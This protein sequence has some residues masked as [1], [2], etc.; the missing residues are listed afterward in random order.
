MVTTLRTR[1]T[2]RASLS[3]VVGRD[4]QATSNAD[5]ARGL[6]AG[7][8]WAISE[9]WHRFAPRVLT[10]AE[11]AVGSRCEAEDLAQEV[12][13]Q[14]FRN[15]ASLREPESLRSFVYSIALRVVRLQLRR[16]RLRAWLLF[17]GP[18]SL[19]D[20]RHWSLDLE[21]RELLRKFYA[22]LERLPPRDRLVFVLRRIDAMTVEEVAAAMDLSASTVKRSML[23]ATNR[24]SRWI[25]ADRTLKEL[26]RGRFTAA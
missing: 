3:L 15:V 17:Q 19:V 1:K 11:R 8:E 12:F 13:Y 26:V 16:R 2:G 5:L 24:L 18:E 20:S 14:V 23:Y 6:I 7:E 22:L 21:S 4:P 10:M 25:E 9:T